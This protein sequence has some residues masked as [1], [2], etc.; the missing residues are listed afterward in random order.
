M[1]FVVRRRP[2]AVLREL[3]AQAAAA[4]I[5]VAPRVGGRGGAARARRIGRPRRAPPRTPGRLRYHYVGRHVA[6]YFDCSPTVLPDLENTLRLNTDVLRFTTMRQNAKMDR[7]N[8]T[9]KNNPWRDDLD[10]IPDV[11]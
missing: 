4:P 10:D 11:R 2:R 6:M 9:K 5:P 3:R 8:S 1:I 7:V